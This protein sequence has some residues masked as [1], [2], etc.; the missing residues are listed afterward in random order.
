[1][2]WLRRTLLPKFTGTREADDAA[3]E[4]SRKISAEVL[5]TDPHVEA[6]H[7][8]A[9]DLLSEAETRSKRM[10]AMDAQNHYSESLTFSMR[11]ETA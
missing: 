3:I 9:L 2:S 10:K 4:N 11:G 7:R 8:K 5:R 6:Q 1:M